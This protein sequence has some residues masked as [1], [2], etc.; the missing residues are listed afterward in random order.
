[1]LRVPGLACPFD[2]Q[3]IRLGGAECPCFS[4][5]GV[6]LNVV[7]LAAQKHRHSTMD[8]CSGSGRI[9]H[10]HRKALTPFRTVAPDPSD[11]EELRIADIDAPE[12]N[13]AC[14]YE[15]KLALRARNRLVELLNS[16]AVEITRMGLDPYGRTLATLH[17]SGRSI[18]D[19]LVSE[20]LARTWSERREPWCSDA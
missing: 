10:D 18:G 13:G 17:R 9:G 4:G 1:M 12:L 14:E 3:M 2:L 11:R 7:V 20:G 15:R 19:Q 16:G 6:R 5:L 8:T